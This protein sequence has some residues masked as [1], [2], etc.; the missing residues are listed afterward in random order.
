MKPYVLFLYLSSILLSVIMA[1]VYRADLK[2]R[3]LFIL[4][5]YL[6]LVFIQELCVFFYIREVPKANTSIIYNFYR[7]ITVVTFSIL[8]YQI[9]FRPIVKKIILL[10]LFL[11]LV[12]IIITFLFL[13]SI[14]SQSNY[15]A[16][17]GGLIITGYA[18]YFLFF[19]FSLDN[20]EQEKQ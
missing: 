4:F 6:L 1:F 20:A 16:T 7:I 17:A 18:I 15:P 13:Q 8:F 5:P 12:L 3:G 9:P 19:Y 2:R 14:Y 11:Y 10:L